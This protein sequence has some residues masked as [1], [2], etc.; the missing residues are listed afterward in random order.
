[1]K[2]YKPPDSIPH[3]AGIIVLLV[4]IIV[5]SFFLKMGIDFIA[6]ATAHRWHNYQILVVLVPSM[7]IALSV[8]CLVQAIRNGFDFVKTVVATG[9]LA[10]LLFAPLV[11][12]LVMGG[13]GV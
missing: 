3:V 8:F 9:L 1:M 12:A 2:I 5:W 13:I 4:D 6:W 10:A 11:F 7:A